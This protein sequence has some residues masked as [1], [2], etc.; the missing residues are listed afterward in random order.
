MPDTVL[1]D[2]VDP[3]PALPCPVIL[4]RMVLTVVLG[5]AIGIACGPGPPWL[6]LLAAGLAVHRRLRPWPLAIGVGRGIHG[7]GSHDKPEAGE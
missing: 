2:I 7:R 4:S 5:D 3:F 6:A 1:A